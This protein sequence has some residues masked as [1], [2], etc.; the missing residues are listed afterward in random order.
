ME[1]NRAVELGRPRLI[2]FSDETHVFLPK[3]FETGPGAQKLAALKDRIGKDRVSA[4]FKSAED[5]RGH[6]V[7]ALARNFSPPPS[8][9]EAELEIALDRIAQ[10]LAKSVEEREALEKAL[11]EANEALKRAEANPPPGESA[12]S[13]E[14]ARQRLADGEKDDA[15][16]IFA[17]IA[18][19]EERAGAA[20]NRKAA[21]AYRNLAALA[22]LDN[23]AEAARLY[24]KAAELDPDDWDS[25]YRL[26]L[27][28]IRM[29]SLAA[30]KAS[31]ESL[32]ALRNRIEDKSLL[33]CALTVLGDIA[34]AAGELRAAKDYF[35][36]SLDIT[37]AR[38]EADPVNA[39]WQ[40]DLGISNERIGDVLMAQGNLFEALKSYQ[41]RHAIISRLAEADP[42]NAGWRRDLSV[43]HNKIGDV[44]RAQGDLA[45]ALASYRASHAIFERLAEA[46]PGNA[47]WQRDLS[48]SLGQIGDVLADQGDLAAA[49]ESYRAS[50]AIRK[51]LAEADPGNAE[52]QRDLSVSLGQIGDVLRAQGD[53]AAA[54]ESY[55]ASHA[56]RKRLAGA[57]P[58]NAGWQTDLAASHGKL[59]LLYRAM[60]DMN[61]ARRYFE[62]GRAIVL[63]LAE[64]SGHQLW[65]GYLRS[66]DEELTA[67][68]E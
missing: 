27:V 4:F 28:Q 68:G 67:L 12:A 42:G 63:P 39:R 2:F 21:E 16:R 64:K 44:Q 19:N 10:R 58:G 59:G 29:G 17:E 7:A 8:R 3:D 45:A 26:S 20:H 33:S 57:D 31:A 40:Y 13:I 61:E 54:L 65:I 11:A 56:I 38:A 6:V 66:F 47:E 50:H 35:E 62:A 18:E 34:V 55:R 60:G 52:W 9:S 5:L 43:S 22:F 23:T 51:R 24:A 15:K 32:L 25:L 41:A 48:V 1:Y 53:L 46:D 14:A 36:Q 49:I 30:A 37:R